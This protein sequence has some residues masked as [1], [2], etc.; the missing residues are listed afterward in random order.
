LV[1]D[2]ERVQLTVVLHRT[3]FTILLLDKEEGRSE[4][5]DRGSDMTTSGHII[6]EGIESSLFHRTKRINLA[7]ILGNGFRFKIDG[8]IP[9]TEWR[10]FV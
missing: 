9:F 6:E 8:M 1:L 3:E 5:G 10:E 4:S 2:R 7:V